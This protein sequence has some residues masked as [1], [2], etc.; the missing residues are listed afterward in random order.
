MT[1]PR[2]STMKRTVLVQVRVEVRGELD[3]RHQ[4]EKDEDEKDK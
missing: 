1:T 2:I 3:W 4:D